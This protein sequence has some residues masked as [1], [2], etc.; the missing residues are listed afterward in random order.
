MVREIS[1]FG[2]AVD[3]GQYVRTITSTFYSY[4]IERLSLTRLTRK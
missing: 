1:C 3:F 4:E 2:L